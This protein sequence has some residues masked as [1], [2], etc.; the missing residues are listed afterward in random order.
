MKDE[1]DK[2][3]YAYSCT[4]HL[5]TGYSPYDLLFGRKLRLPANRPRTD[6]L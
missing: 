6:V 5:V 2:L 1:I 3:V 4:K